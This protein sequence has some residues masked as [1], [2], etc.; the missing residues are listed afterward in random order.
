VAEVKD[1]IKVSSLFRFVAGFV[2][3]AISIFLGKGE[4]S[5]PAL[6]TT[7]P[8]WGP[9]PPPPPPGLTPRGVGAR[10]GGAVCGLEEEEGGG[11]GR[12]R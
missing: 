4:T 8:G 3:V 1:F 2:I 5:L 6:A 7:R 11:E 10:A 12:G 9:P